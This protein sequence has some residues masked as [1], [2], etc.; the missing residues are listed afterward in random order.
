MMEDRA[1]F[2]FVPDNVKELYKQLWK[3]TDFPQHEYIKGLSEVDFHG[4]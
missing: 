1:Q 2:V 4:N 3:G